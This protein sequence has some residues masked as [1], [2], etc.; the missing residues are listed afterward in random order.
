LHRQLTASGVSVC[1]STLKRYSATFGWQERLSEF[2]VETRKRRL[3]RGVED[4]LAMHDRHAQLARAV[5]GAAGSALQRLLNSDTRLAGLRPTEIARLID[6]G[7]RAERSA[8]G[9][10]VDRREIAVETWNEVVSSVVDIFSEIN[11]EPDERVRARL[12]AKRLDKLVDRKL[13]A[14]EQEET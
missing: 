10:I 6:L 14:Y 11:D 5:Q 9:N 12:F 13:A 1:L 8:V 2:D 4:T 7:L 3:D